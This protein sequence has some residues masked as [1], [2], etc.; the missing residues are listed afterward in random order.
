MSIWKR[1]AIVLAFAVGPLALSLNTTPAEESAQQSEL[2]NDSLKRQQVEFKNEISPFLNSYCVACHGPDDQSGERRFDVLTGDISDLNS[3]ADYQDILDQ[4]NLGTMPPSDETQP[5]TDELRKTIKWLTQAIATFHET[6]RPTPSETVLRR[7]NAREYKNTIRDLFNLKTLIFDP[8]HGFP[9]DRAVD[10]LD[11]I[12]ESLVI[13]GYQLERYLDAAEI[14]VNKA[15]F[16]VEQPEIQ[17]WRFTDGFRQQKEI[18]QVHVKVTGFDHLRLYDV[19]GADKHEGGYAPI[20]AF[21]EGVP[22]DGVYE[23]RFLAEAVNRKHP[24]DPDFLGTDPDEP[25]RLGIVPGDHLVGHL[26]KPQP[27]EPLLAAI[28]LA[29]KKEWYSVDVWLDAGYTPRFTFENGLMDA[30]NLWSKLI[31]KYPDDFPKQKRPGIV[32]ARFNAIKYGKL[33]Q[34][35]IHEVE[36]QGPIYKQWPKPSQQVV[37]GDDWT[38]VAATENLPPAQLHRH[39]HQFL[40]RAYRRP[41]TDEEIARI[42]DVIDARSQPGRSNIEALSDGLKTVLCSPN[43]LYLDEGEEGELSAYALASRLSYFL[44]SSMPDEELFQLADSGEILKEEVIREQVE[45]MLESPKSSEFLDGFLGSWLTLRDLG[46]SPPDRKDFSKFYHYDLDRAMRQETI[47]FAQHLLDENLSV[48][49]FLD[50]DFTFVNKRL[51][52]HYDIDVEFENWYDFQQVALKDNRRGGLLGQA[53]V[54]TVTANGIDTSPVVRGVWILENLLGTPP[55]PPPPDIEPL[56]PDVRGTTTIREQLQKHRDNPACNDCHRS[57]DPPG[58]ALENFDAIGGWRNSYGKGK[59]IDA[60]SEL[61]TG[62]SFKDVRDFKTLLRKHPDTF[63]RGLTGKLLAY[64]M[65]REIHPTD[66]PTID[67]IVQELDES[68][69]GFRDLIVLVALSEPFRSR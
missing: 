67:R 49:N 29:D 61:A 7:L 28:D 47:F 55:T 34:I 15:M 37:L 50:S 52:D 39:L 56:D 16:P 43:F 48:L 59:P 60:S 38:E 36:I 5:S 30:R 27:I 66:R 41:A 23:I 58:F 14:I 54:L 42:V 31:R 21:A 45:R 64:S 32:E 19:R 63:L 18:D 11:N 65:G 4:L 8:S 33:P 2:L 44:W 10:H 69:H 53:S 13:S 3:L 46:S 40:S 9:K 62:E 6:H 26:H 25:L 24:Y 20:H 1:C 22:E 68:G 51:A 12:G 17:T 35:R 57:I